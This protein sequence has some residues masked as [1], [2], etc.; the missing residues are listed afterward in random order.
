MLPI[1]NT[2]GSDIQRISF[3]YYR[4]DILQRVWNIFLPEML[5]SADNSCSLAVLH[6]GRNY[7]SITYFN[8]VVKSQIIVNRPVIA[9]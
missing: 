1:L 5:N 4:F 7:D 6:S 8:G 2:D 3:S 9:E